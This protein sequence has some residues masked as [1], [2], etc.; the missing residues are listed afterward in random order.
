MLINTI[1]ATT[2]TATINPIITVDE[3]YPY[4]VDKKIVQKVNEGATVGFAEWKAKL[5]VDYPNFKQNVFTGKKYDECKLIFADW[6]K[7]QGTNEGANE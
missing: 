6:L 2:A 1:N 7:V 3:I 4:E 5:K